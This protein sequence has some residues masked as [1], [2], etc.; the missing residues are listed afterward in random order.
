M[1]ERNE[2]EERTAAAGWYSDPDSAGSL[3]YWDGRE[4][5]EHRSRDVIPGR[6]STG[7]AA[8]SAGRQVSLGG[9]AIIGAVLSFIGWSLAAENWPGA[10]FRT[11]GFDPGGEWVQTGDVTVA[12][13]GLG[14]VNVGALFVLVAVIAWGVKFGIRAAQEA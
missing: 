12:F 9:L 8:R 14:L 10:E 3:R 1:D 11:Y 5:T 13:L 7:A 4:W 6:T 2:G